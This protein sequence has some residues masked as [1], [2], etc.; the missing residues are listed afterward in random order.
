MHRQENIAT[1][2]HC[3]PRSRDPLY[4]EIAQENSVVTS[5]KLN[6]IREAVWVTAPNVLFWRNMEGSVLKRRDQ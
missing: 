2:A 3:P 1:A 6:L 4:S 5:F